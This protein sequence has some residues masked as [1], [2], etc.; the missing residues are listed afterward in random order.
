MKRKYAWA[1]VI[2]FGV[3]FFCMVRIVVP[4]F[5]AVGNK[6]SVLPA[7]ALS[8]IAEPDDGIAPVLAM[9]NGATKSVDLVMYELD[10]AQVEAALAADER[11]GVAV[12]VLLSA[13]YDGASSTVNGPAYNFLLAH[14]VAVRWSPSYFSLTHEKSLV[15]DG[16]RALIMT[17]NLTSKYYATG[18][19]FG[20]V[21]GDTRDIT[22]MERTFGDDWK[23]SDG[24]SGGSGNA[25]LGGN[26]GDA[27]DD[28]VWS[29]GSEPALITLINSAQK[30]L[31]IYN[32]EMAD[33]D[34]TKALID[35][36]ERGVAVYVVM[37]GA[38][39]WKW[40]F[41]ELATAGV[42]VR[43]YAD[44][45]SA[46]LYIHAKVIV[47]DEGSLSARAFVGSE[48]FSAASL[49]ENRELGIMISDPMII[50]SLMK[51]FSADWRNASS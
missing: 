21:D 38:D 31:Y 24:G 7:G 16:S 11:R 37:T 32:E 28:L 35:A 46:P 20:I 19:D 1:I 29:P 42:H 47:A 25:S 34:V 36:A 6:N 40:D 27:G 30:S 45:A 15:V 4:K 41:A 12:R 50:K 49:G 17:F 2:F 18:R 10:D 33:M 14:G 48:N 43:T 13:G 9:I 8:L 26:H 39:E 23:G 5:F 51:T 3:A 22:A 44:D